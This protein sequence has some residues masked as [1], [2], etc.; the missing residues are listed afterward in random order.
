MN[1]IE[2]HRNTDDKHTCPRNQHRR[3][4]R[5]KLSSVITQ[6]HHRGT[7]TLE[8]ANV[9]LQSHFTL[10]LIMMEWI[11]FDSTRC[12]CSEILNHGTERIL[13]QQQECMLNVGCDKS[14]QKG[15][16][17]RSVVRSFRWDWVLF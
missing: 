3:T 10:N 14:S 16:V 13:I 4:H 8:L 6:S 7:K 12:V 1:L 9:T 2:S 15:F 17:M 11:R 5:A